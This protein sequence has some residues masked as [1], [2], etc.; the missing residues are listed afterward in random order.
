MQHKFEQDGLTF[1]TQVPMSMPASPASPFASSTSYISPTPK[2][3]RSTLFL[4]LLKSLN[5]KRTEM[6]N[7]MEIHFPLMSSKYVFSYL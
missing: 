1:S 7:F 5:V 3:S 6:K 2:T 4:L